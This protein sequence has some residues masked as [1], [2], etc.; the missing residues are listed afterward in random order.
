MTVGAGAYSTLS[1][2]QRDLFLANERYSH[3]KS[4]CFENVDVAV[5]SLDNLITRF[6]RPDYIKID[7]E[8]YETSVLAGLSEPIC[9]ISFEANLPDF[10]M[11]TI[12]CIERL[13]QISKGSVFNFTISDPPKL[14]AS[15]SWLSHGE[16]IAV[17]K[18]RAF[19]YMEIFSK[20]M[21][22]KT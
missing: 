4:E 10:E 21:N 20:S 7:V 12:D 11:E 16:M 17:V 22:R 5:V 1:K 6:G 3:L 9:L 19:E 8:G 15:K 2:K 13:A 18:S 14:F